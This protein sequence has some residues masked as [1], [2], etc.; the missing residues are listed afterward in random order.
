MKNFFLWNLS[1]DVSKADIRRIKLLN[2]CC[3]IASSINFVDFLV[4]FKDGAIALAIVNLTSSLFFLI[5]L[6]LSI[7]Q[8][9][10]LSRIILIF[11]APPNFFLISLIFAQ[12]I[13]IQLYLFSFI[14]L[15]VFFLKQKQEIYLALAWF[16]LFF[17][18]MSLGIQYEWFPPLKPSSEKW[19]SFF[20]LNNVTGAIFA[21]IIF[22]TILRSE[23]FSY[24][25]KLR[26]QNL[27][28]A[29]QKE[30]LHLSLEELRSTQEF[31]EHKQQEITKKNVRIERLYK[32]LNS[33][34]QYA[35]NIQKSILPSPQKLKQLLPD[36]FVL[37]KP[38][39]IVSGDFY[40]LEEVK[41]QIVLA[42]IDCTGHGVPGAFMSMIGND[43]LTEIVKN[44]CITKPAQILENLHTGVRQLLKQE[45]TDNHDGM[46]I[47]LVVIDLRHQSLEFAGAINP[48]VYVQ[49]NELKIIKGNKAPIGG[50][51]KESIREFT[52]HR[53]SLEHPFTFYLF[54]D[55][56]QDQFGGPANK[57]FMRTR[58]YELLLENHQQPLEQQK[59]SLEEAL[60]KWQGGE[61]QIDDVLVIGVRI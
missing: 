12:N 5:P 10:A 57:K 46:D 36:S 50:E 21:M 55:G 45:D 54:S 22:A 40:Y 37:F 4:L 3:F 34:I 27:T 19:V 28:L 33:S 52:S 17:F 48:F 30:E 25:S 59:N 24:E 61:S 8:K 6:L 18:L 26:Q 49:N 2:I 9:Y 47:S 44:K 13:A 43:L 7:Y 35:Q 20:W 15:A 29:E 14:N 1:P 16:C 23:T 56:F 32:D 38:R 31:L 58:F 53:I 39:D 41:G 60:E 42:A 51:Q 11:G